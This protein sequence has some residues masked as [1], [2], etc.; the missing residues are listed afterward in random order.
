MRE[1]ER[2]SL[3]ARLVR[4]RS[5][6]QSEDPYQLA[7]DLLAHGRYAE[8][9]SVARSAL[10]A[11][12]EEAVLLLLE[13][14]A[15]L[16][17]QDLVRA[18]SML[19][20]AVAQSPELQQG[21]RYLGEVLLQRGDVERAVKTLRRALAL[22]PD[23]ADSAA[24][25]AEAERAALVSQ[26]SEELRSV[27]PRRSPSRA[28][29]VA[30]PSA[31]S[32]RSAPVGPAA[33]VAPVA[34]ASTRERPVE[35]SR[36]QTSASDTV[37]EQ[38][39]PS[40][41]GLSGGARAAQPRP[42]AGLDARPSPRAAD[43]AKAQGAAAD[44]VGRAAVRAPIA[45]GRMEP[46]PGEPASARA[47][48][49]P[50]FA[51]PNDQTRQ[52][53]PRR[54]R[55]DES[56]ASGLLS[57][58]A[59]E[60]A[61]R[62]VSSEPRWSMSEGTAPSDAPPPRASSVAGGHTQHAH[63]SQRDQ[64]V[65]RSV[66]D[67][68]AAPGLRADDARAPR[69]PGM[70]MGAA[71]APARPDLQ[72]SAAKN[73]RVAAS[74]NDGSGRAHGTA[75]ANEHPWSRSEPA[76][77]R[78]NAVDDDAHQAPHDD[79]N[80]AALEQAD[81]VCG[82]EL[83]AP[84]DADETLALV[85]R[86]GLFEQPGEA[87]MTWAAPGEVEQSGQRL[88]NTVIGV[89]TLALV[90]AVGGYFGF[91]AYV[92]KRH[93]EAARLLGEA[94]KLALRADHAALGEA[95]RLLRVAREL[96]PSSQAIPREALLLQV[97]RLVDD[98]ERD[99][100]ALRS[101]MTRAQKAA[102]TGPELA[103]A[104]ALIAL[105][106]DDAAGHDR[107]L[108]AL[109]KGTSSD[110][111][112]QYLLGRIEQRTGRQQAFAHL[113]AAAQ[114]AP[115]LVPA[116]IAVAIAAYAAG[117]RAAAERSLRAT[118]AAVPEALR[119][120][121]VQLL[122]AADDTEPRALTQ[123]LGGFAPALKTAG[124]TDRALVALLHARIARRSAQPKVA[125]AAVLEASEA[126]SSDP[127]VLAW[128]ARESL[129]LGN[130]A[131]AQTL[132]SQALIAQ[133]DDATTRRL[134][135]RILIDR[136]DGAHA[137]LLLDKFPV[138]DSEAQLLFGEAALAAGDSAAQKR[139]LAALTEQGREQGTRAAALRL[140]I[141]AKQT[142]GANLLARARTLAK[143]APGDPDALF[144][145][146]ETALAVHDSATAQRALKQLLVVTP[147]D[148][149]A[150]CLLGRTL[151]STGDAAGAEASLRRA[152][153]LTPGHVEALA[154]LASLLLDEGKYTE[155]EAAFRRL[156]LG[157]GSA[158]EGRLGRVEAL[159]GLEQL[160]A[161]QVQL[162]AIPEPQRTGPGFR[163]VAARLALARGEPGAALSQL[164]PLI[165]AHEHEPQ[166]LALY[167]DALAFAQ[168]P[169]AAAS[170]FASALAADS[171]LPEALLGSA[172]LQLVPSKLKQ[173]LALLEKAQQSLR[174]RIRPPAVQA[175]RLYLLG[176]VYLTRSK[177]GDTE[178]AREALSEAVQLQGVPHDAY[179]FLGEAL[180][181][182]GH[183]EAV[184]A[185]KHYLELEPRGRY[186][187]RV[188]R[189]IGGSL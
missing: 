187:E 168:Q 110:A 54:H 30:G 152:L 159:V 176:R 94:Q 112:L 151:R 184:T 26:A 142:P 163:E 14:R 186:R 52:A 89:W 123:A 10:T 137:L 55:D 136:R 15:F 177:R 48:P 100:S 155:A 36:T 85:Q 46:T 119:V 114:A 41:P 143:N 9:R 106:T 21:Y 57:D 39:L 113:Q 37:R 4:Y 49:K 173:A 117:D 109:A 148:A 17:D 126:G 105:A 5:Q 172:E 138:E 189:A 42:L 67:Q 93:A 98:D 43:S 61:T 74:A 147:D 157:S 122:A 167:G 99:V 145:L 161:A 179:Y 80:A 160:D 62:P 11:G 116:Q 170:A 115:K 141:E 34:R 65:R 45:L 133:P 50:Y 6:P 53:R 96:H 111:R 82:A 166:L 29:Q 64:G 70:P 154:A 108:E 31:G 107:A 90:L 78:V 164:R 13:G 174:G 75:A 40:A 104:Q 120:Q 165:D 79:A 144:A 51:P 81:V 3:N 101:A 24:F 146:T 102:V 86:L 22:A 178:T 158:L 66:S 183:A 127:R 33:P 84:V 185:F 130:L 23:D 131:L 156:V 1:H 149:D 95:E 175:R 88:R 139:A 134:L 47:M 132:A 25:L 71:A 16:G 12:G 182:Q 180:G 76:T 19:Q 103:L 87:P 129:T 7:E 128:I 18:Q 77:A 118:H 169:D 181:G 125:L 59:A 8:A 162:D 92:T 27:F 20:R 73:A 72:P 63:P 35:S 56:T 58:P 121:L 140:R 44:G 97:E 68:R 69:V 135:A 2:Q 38:R 188:R 153:D 91:Q 60:S 83:H 171:G 150:H 32:S 124:N 28:P